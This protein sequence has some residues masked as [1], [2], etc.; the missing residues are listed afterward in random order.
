VVDKFEQFAFSEKDLC[1]PL[2]DSI[3]IILFLGNS[4]PNGPVFQYIKQLPEAE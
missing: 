2:A 3:N 1:H 4:F